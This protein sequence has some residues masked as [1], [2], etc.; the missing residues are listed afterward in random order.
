MKMNRR[1]LRATLLAGLLAAAPAWALPS[2]QI[3]VFSGGASFPSQPSA[4]SDQWST[5]YALCG[6]LFWRAAPTLSLGVEIGYYRHGLDKEALQGRFQDTFPGVSVSGR[7][8]WIMPLSAV[9]ELDL[10]RWGVVKPFLRAGF[11]VY[12]FGTTPLEASGPGAD[13]VREEVSADP[14][15]ENLDGTVFGTLIGLGIH[16]PIT[17]VLTLVF[18]ATYHVANTTGESTHFIPVRVGLRF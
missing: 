18:D 7:S 9:G 8:L 3:L 1:I 13:E 5:G 10:M 15:T 17:P 6:G 14:L 16:T 11:G 2:G 4:V 12:T